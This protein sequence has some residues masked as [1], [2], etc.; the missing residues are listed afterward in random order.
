MDLKDLSKH[1]QR[2][3][4]SAVTGLAKHYRQSPDKLTQEMIEVYLLY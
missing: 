3:Y 1:T 2:T 4:L